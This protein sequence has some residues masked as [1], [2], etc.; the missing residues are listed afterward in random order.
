M[1]VQKNKQAIFLS[2][3]CACPFTTTPKE[4]HKIYKILGIVVIKSVDCYG[5]IQYLEFAIEDVDLDSFS[6]SI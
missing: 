2:N 6:V 4:I 3:D 1:L 5:K